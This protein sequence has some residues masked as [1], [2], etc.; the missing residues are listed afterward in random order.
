MHGAV[1]ENV[2]GARMQGEI[3][4]VEDT[5][6]SLKLLSDLL[7]AAGYSVRQAP[8]GELALWTAA[9]RAP[10]LILLDIRMPG[11]DG[12]EVC[13]R[14]KR[15]PLTAAVPVIFLSALAD[16]DDKIEGL[17]A[18]AVDYVGKP[19][20]PGEVLARVKSHVTVAQLRRELESERQSLELKVR[21]RTADLQALLDAAVE[22]AVIAVDPAGSITLFNRG[23]Q[24]MLG[25]SESEM[26]GCSPARF[27]RDSEIQQRAA[28]LSQ[29][30]G[31]PVEGFETFVA[32]ARDGITEPHTWTYVRKDGQCLQ[33]S[34][35]VSP[36]RDAQGELAGFLGIARDITEQLAAEADLRQLNL[37]LDRRVQERTAALQQTTEQLQHALDELR[38]AQD[39]LVRAE[40]LSAMGAIVTAVAHELN[41]P[42]GNCMVVASTLADKI[43]AIEDHIA[44][45]RLRRS[46]L[47]DYMQSVRNGMQ[48]MLRGLER[49][50]TLVTDFKQVAA[51]DHRSNRQTFDLQEVLETLCKMLMKP[52]RASA[53]KLSFECAAPVAMDSYPESITQ[54]VSHLVNNS[55]RHGFLGRDSGLMRLQVQ[56]EAEAVRLL[57]SDDG[58]GMSEDVLRQVFK[59]FFT[60]TLGQ[61]SSGL[62]MSVCYNLVT[63]PL[64]GTIDVS[65]EPGAGSACAIVLPLVAPRGDNTR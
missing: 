56:A 53:Y 15:D 16:A 55:L 21:Q 2:A 47:D 25:Y 48:L 13:R 26:L 45:G 46:E 36:V 12:L 5:P 11:I 27:H 58:V 8:N 54:V 52:W 28:Q 31:R 20:A 63:G 62:G 9:Q 64:G 18:G 19:Y 51:V 14:L 42:I 7:S 59:P 40:N 6:A 65:S 43:S 39:K 37:E 22:V 24:K 49:A 32:L 3:L 33:V 23:A 61:G 41:T 38:L 34:L 35:A 1:A 44:S 30:L 10:D 4:V 60:T 17:A 57:Y 29:A 50:A